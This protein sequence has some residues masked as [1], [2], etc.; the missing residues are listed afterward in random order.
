MSE[1]NQISAVI[2]PENITA[3][4]AKIAEAAALLPA[5]SDITDKAL[6]H[7]LGIDGSTELDE[8]AAEALAAHPEWKPFVVD[9][10]E[11]PKDTA[12]FTDTAPMDA[13]VAALARKIVVIRRKAAHDTRRATL[14]I[15][16]QV[17][18]LAARGNVDAQG[19][20]DRM[21]PHFPGRPP[22]P[23]TPPTP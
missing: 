21:S 10:T 11:Y 12:L 19:Y 13:A 20:Y 22:K 16:N 2:T 9:A 17:A 5:S 15:Y 18:E 7:L 4:I 6:K 8:I 1:D 23:P 3:F 14:A